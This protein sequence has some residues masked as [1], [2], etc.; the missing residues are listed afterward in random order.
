MNTIIQ[1]IVRPA[2]RRLVRVVAGAAVAVGFV[3]IGAGCEGYTGEGALIGGGLGVAG[4]TL[5]GGHYGRPVE[6]ALIGGLI[7]GSTGAAIGAQKD[8]QRERARNGE[9]YEE[10]YGHGYEDASPRRPDYYGR[11]PRGGYGGGYGYRGGYD[12]YDPY[13]DY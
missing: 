10:G 9:Y 12:G 1:T 2:R 13:C 8:L 7:G 3:G 4:G 6:G 11:Q 5:V